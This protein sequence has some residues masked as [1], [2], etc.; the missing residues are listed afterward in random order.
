[1]QRHLKE[2]SLKFL[3]RFNVLIEGM[4]IIETVSNFVSGKRRFL[5]SRLVAL[6]TVKRRLA[7]KIKSCFH[8][9]SI[10]DFFGS[11]GIQLKARRINSEKS[12]RLKV[13]LLLI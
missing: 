2:P 13:A 3:T 7:E 6:T 12:L 8:W 11:I 4:F 9:D 10:E 1:M 5:D